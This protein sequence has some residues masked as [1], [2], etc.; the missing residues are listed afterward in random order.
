MPETKQQSNYMCKL[1]CWLVLHIINEFSDNKQLSNNIDEV[2]QC[3]YNRN[4]Y[5]ITSQ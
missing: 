5:N 2:N 3:F 4:D 1:A